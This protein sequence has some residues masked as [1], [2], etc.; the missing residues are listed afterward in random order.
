MYHA[1]APCRRCFIY[2]PPKPIS[3]LHRVCPER[4][5]PGQQTGHSGA[6]L[7]GS[8]GALAVAPRLPSFASQTC[9]RRRP[10]SWTVGNPARGGPAGGRAIRAYLLGNFYQ[11]G[12]AL[13]LMPFVCF[14]LDVIFIIFM[15]F[16]I[17]VSFVFFVPFVFF[18]LNVGFFVCFVLD[19]IF[20]SFVFL[21][22]LCVVNANA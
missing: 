6:W 17:F 5:P 7:E 16:M 1:F 10:W 12:L 9:T 19:V 4:V 2:R 13:F 21:C 18:V 11:N 3:G 14:V 8:R 15:I 20:V 22:H